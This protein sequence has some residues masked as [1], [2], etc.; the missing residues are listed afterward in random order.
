M[1]TITNYAGSTSQHDFH[2]E[3]PLHQK[4]VILKEYFENGIRYYETKKSDGIKAIF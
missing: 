1:K 3:V 4:P 2:A